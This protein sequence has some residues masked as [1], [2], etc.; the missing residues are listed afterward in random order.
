MVALVESKCGWCCK[1]VARNYAEARIPSVLF[2]DAECRSAA[3]K[4][5]PESWVDET[6]DGTCASHPRS[7]SSLGGHSLGVGHGYSVYAGG[8]RCHVCREANRIY[9]VRSKMRWYSDAAAGVLT[10]VDGHGMNGYR[11]GCRC[12]VCRAAKAVENRRFR[13][14]R[15]SA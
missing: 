13:R 9:M 11:H 6:S 12:E 8:C 7:C 14:A 2:C 5:D 3:R 4:H 10:T 15:M 1:P